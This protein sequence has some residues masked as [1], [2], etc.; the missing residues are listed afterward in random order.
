MCDY[1]LSGVEA[2]NYEARQEVDIPPIKP[3]V[4]EHRMLSKICPNFKAVN[5]AEGPKNLTQAIQYGPRLIATTA[6]FTL[7][8]FIPL[9]RTKDQ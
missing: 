8:Q 5:K 3:V 9:N 4:T 6:Y 2:K 1:D 7:Q